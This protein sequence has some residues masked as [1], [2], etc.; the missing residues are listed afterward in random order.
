MLGFFE[1]PPVVEAEIMQG[2]FSL[3]ISP[4]VHFLSAGVDLPRIST[5]E[6]LSRLDFLYT[7]DEYDDYNFFC[8]S[9][10]E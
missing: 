4:R 2:T 1:H 6:G 10:Y 7:I 3:G 9:F 8:W 5:F